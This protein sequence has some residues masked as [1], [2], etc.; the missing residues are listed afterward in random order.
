MDQVRLSHTYHKVN[1]GTSM[2]RFC[3]IFATLSVILLLNQ[4]S[5]P[6]HAQSNPTANSLVLLDHATGFTSLPNGVEVRDGDA[7]EQILALR[8]DLLRIR[9]ARHSELPEDAS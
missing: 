6:L 7:R 9:I 2:Q 5:A 3:S 8:D 4:A 1:L